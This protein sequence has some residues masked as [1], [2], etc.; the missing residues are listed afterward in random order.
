MKILELKTKLA[1]VAAKYSKTK[2]EMEVN[3]KSLFTLVLGSHA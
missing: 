3:C 1:E 2:E